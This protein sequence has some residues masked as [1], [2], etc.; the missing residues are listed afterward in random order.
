MEGNNKF[1]NPQSIKMILKKFSS[2]FRNKEFL[3]NFNYIQDDL[4]KILNLQPKEPEPTSVGDDETTCQPTESDFV[5]NEVQKNLK[6]QS[7][8]R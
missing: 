5:E 6:N 3:L 8:L 1:G 2:S 4:Y 7:R